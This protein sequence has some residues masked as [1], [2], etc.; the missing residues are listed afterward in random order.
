MTYEGAVKLLAKGDTPVIDALEQALGLGLL[1]VTVFSPESALPYF[2]AKNEL[3]ARLRQLSDQAKQRMT[4]STRLEYEDLLGAA[5]A[6]IVMTAFTEEL[7]ERLQELD[8]TGKW[9]R[10]LRHWQGTQAGDRPK[11]RQL[12][13]WSGQSAIEPPG[14]TRPTEVVRAEVRNVY[15]RLSNQ[16]LD[17]LSGLRRW[18]ELNDTERERIEHSIGSRRFVERAV[19][20]YWEHFLHLAVEV[21]EYLV[22]T[23]LNEH[24]STRFILGSLADRLSGRDAEIRSILA[25]LKELLRANSAALGDLPALLAQLTRPSGDTLDELLLRVDECHSLH[26]L[27]LGKP[28]LTPRLNG[29]LELI[30]FP[31]ICEGYINPN[32]R[33]IETER[34]DEGRR[35]AQEESWRGQPARSGLGGFLA[36]Y[37]RSARATRLP[38]LVLG[39]PGSGKSLL[40]KILAAQ[41]P[42]DE[43]AVARVELRHV[44]SS[45]EVSDQ[46]D[47]EL[48]RQTNNR[49]Q[50]HNLTDP[51]GRI[52]RVVIMDGLD[53]LL[54]LSAHEGLGG[55]LERLAEFQ[56]IEAELGR[57]VIAVATARTI[58]MDRIYVPKDSVILKLEGFSDDQICTWINAWNRENAPYF[59]RHGLA[60]LSADTIARHIDLARQP[61]LLALLALYDAEGN[62][63][64]NAGDLDQTELYER[65]FRRYLER[66]LEK[67]SMPQRKNEQAQLI[68]QR[69]RELSTIATGMLNRG[70]RFITRQEV[71]QDYAAKEIRRGRSERVLGADDAVGQF[72]FLYRAQAQHRDTTFYEGYEFIHSTF[73]EFLSARILAQQLVRAAE[74]MNAAPAWDQTQAER[75]A[76]A[77]LAP[78]LAQRP[79]VGEEQVLLFLETIMA[80]QFRRRTEAARSIARHVPALMRSGLGGVPGS[81]PDQGHLERLAILTLNLMLAAL[82]IDARSINLGTLFENGRDLLDAWRQLLALW[83]A[84][85]AADDWVRI[86]ES[87]SLSGQQLAYGASTSAETDGG[88]VPRG[89]SSHVGRLAAEGQLSADPDL[90]GAAMVWHLL[91][92]SSEAEQLIRDEEETV[93]E[94]LVSFAAFR[95]SPASDQIPIW[96]LQKALESLTA[97][98]RTQANLIDLVMGGPASWNA[99][100]L[101]MVS[102]LLL[103]HSSL[104]IITRRALIRLMMEL[105]RRELFA[106]ARRLLGRVPETD[107]RSAGPHDT[108]DLVFLL[109]RHQL[110]GHLRRSIDINEIDDAVL[111]QLRIDDL[112]WI[113]QHGGFAEAELQTLARHLQGDPR[114]QR[115]LADVQILIERVQRASD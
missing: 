14:P 80:G 2:D 47:L 111:E 40:S 24:A 18:D 38:L 3:M 1:A 63:L 70:R 96:E 13:S 82:L 7:T 100:M 72:F 15:L 110:R 54:Q 97:N 105:D 53:E 113:F 11:C 17:Y 12:V 51:Q 93:S 90:R 19:D 107:G 4:T 8:A 35:L 115:N 69:F 49:Y 79:L 75:H 89:T 36:G 16:A 23:L 77:Q 9:R 62:S 83:K 98:H 30:S 55:Y 78:Y 64:R 71:D 37:F 20:R 95:I 32:F 21:P 104:A 34:S 59:E 114:Y 60:K 44:R 67:G 73:G 41:L 85:L 61:L 112:T 6:V 39:D 109:R 92:L 56:E 29:D 87:L 106:N 76:L 33:M 27:I 42:P 50:L 45:Q 52:T 48:R 28:L 68:E 43:F 31:P 26:R 81:A 25:G 65:I 103:E 22:W 91:S 86:L 58:V 94:D 46:I 84:H 99:K 101:V 5:H 66:E 74:I 102:T 10:E 57:P 88:L 108:A